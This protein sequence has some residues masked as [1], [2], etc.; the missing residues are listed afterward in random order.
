MRPHFIYTSRR[1]QVDDASALWCTGIRGQRYFFKDTQKWSE[2]RT[3]N[4]NSHINA[5]NNAC[6]YGRGVG[7]N[8]C[9][10]LV[11]FPFPQSCP[12]LR[13]AQNH[14]PYMFWRED[15]RVSARNCHR[16]SLL[17]LSV[18][19]EKGKIMWTLGRYCLQF[20][21][22]HLRL[23]LWA[24]TAWWKATM[25]Q[26]TFHSSMTQEQSTKVMSHYER[27]YCHLNHTEEVLRRQMLGF[28]LTAR[29]HSDN[30]GRKK[31]KL[32]VNYI[33]TALCG[34]LTSVS[35]TAGASCWVCHV[36]KQFHQC[37]GTSHT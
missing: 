15:I 1:F 11:A 24:I 17:C 33:V 35:D 31:E 27:R 30:S 2:T 3:A 7:R 8:R 22:K 29:L 13:L 12:W 21:L 10:A 19:F 37:Y 9:E 34:Y 6:V 26:S 4:K 18:R 32:C 28:R 25:K 14:Q 23:L 5:P 20:L 36:C 16:N